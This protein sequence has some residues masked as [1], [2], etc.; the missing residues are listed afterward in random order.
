MFIAAEPP[1][2]WLIY[3]PK[4]KIND[5]YSPDKNIAIK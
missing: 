4:V 5:L 1:R 3:V 2:E